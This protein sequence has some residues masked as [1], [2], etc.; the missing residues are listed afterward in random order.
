MQ[1]SAS[2]GYPSRPFAQR[3]TIQE[4][5]DMYD[6]AEEYIVEQAPAGP[7]K[8]NLDL[9]LVGGAARAH[10]A[11]SAQG[12]GSP[13]APAMPPPPGGRT[14]APA[15]PRQPLTRVPP[16]PAALLQY[17][18]RLA[19][20]QALLTTDQARRRDL[21][22]Q[23]EDGLRRCLTM[24]AADGRTYVV[25]GKLLVQQKRFDEARKLYADGC[26][27]TGAGRCPQQRRRRR[28][29]RRHPRQPLLMQRQA[30]LERRLAVLMIRCQCS[31]VGGWGV[32]Q[33]AWRQAPTTGR[34][35]PAP[36]CLQATRT[37]S[38]GPPGA[39]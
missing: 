4:M 9:L 29:R 17:R 32:W 26:T 5:E 33:Q 16:P 6:E 1:A 10:G 24:N 12:Q 15:P 11:A 34:A 19:R 22:K 23:A 14:C 36:R 2:D 20:M 38:Y 8:I 37:P 3:V 13:I 25:L 35:L 31:G 27:N 7:L 30:A 21:F 28:R 18:C 39:T